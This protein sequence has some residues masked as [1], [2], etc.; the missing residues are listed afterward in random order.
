[1]VR[2]PYR[3]ARQQHL[4][5]ALDSLAT[6]GQL[7]WRWEYDVA[8]SRAVFNVTLPGENEEALDTRT[9]EALVQRLMADVGF[10]WIPVPH[11]GGERQLEV[12]LR[13]MSE[14]G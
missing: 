6:L 3:I 11:P 9:A 5:E 7:S 14:P 1:M 8:R 4:G 12:A 2:V 13:Q 10:R